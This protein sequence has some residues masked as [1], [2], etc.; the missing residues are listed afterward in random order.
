MRIVRVTTP[1]Q[2]AVALAVR[3]EVFVFEQRVAPEAE[4]DSWDDDPSTIHV[5]ALVDDP[6]DEVDPTRDETLGTGRLL[7]PHGDGRP[8][9]GRVAV[10]AR[11]RGKGVGRAI[12][13]A[14]EEAALE[15]HGDDG[16]VVVALAAQVQAIPFYESIGY[17]I[18]GERFLD[19]GI[20]HREATKH[21]GAAPGA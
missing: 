13:A 4:Q 9:I 15:A 21:V 16:S 10:V 2:F 6:T 17:A 7:A 5:L 3:T 19:E 8:H 20:W 1:E 18:H 14:L 11:A 12:M